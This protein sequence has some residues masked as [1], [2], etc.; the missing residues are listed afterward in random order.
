MAKYIKKPVEIE[1]TQWNLGDD[2]LSCMQKFSDVI[3]EQY[4]AYEGHYFIKTLEGD[5]LVSNGDYVITGVTGENYPC[6]PDI[7]EAT[8]YTEDEYAKLESE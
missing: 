1:A 5:H 3:L 8:Y 7:F 6:K 2:P 4:P